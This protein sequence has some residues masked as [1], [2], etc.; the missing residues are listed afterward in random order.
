MK[1]IGNLGSWILP[2]FVICL[3]ATPRAASASP[4]R[5]VLSLYPSPTG[6]DWQSP[7]ELLVSAAVNTLVKSR[8][9]DAHEIGHATIELA[10]PSIGVESLHV[11]MTQADPEESNRLLFREGAGLDILFRTMAGRLQADAEIRRNL[12]LRRRSGRLSRIEFLVRSETCARLLEYFREYEARG[13]GALYGLPNRPRHGEGAGCSAFAVSFLELG[14]L[15]HPEFVQ[16]WR[17]TV[18]A[19]AALLGDDRRPVSLWQVFASSASGRWAFATEP[20]RNVTFW[21]PDTMHRWTTD[22]LRREGKRG[23][24]LRLDARHVP[25]PLSPIWKR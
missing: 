6:M 25:T 1:R 15:L 4:D 18:R 21:D 19:P 8:A 9:P 5:V 3:G 10:C 7:R 12:D 24:T 20:G 13:Y 16:G 22:R 14:G 11:G 23:N 17:L 2:V